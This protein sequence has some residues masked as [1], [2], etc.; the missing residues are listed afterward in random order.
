M[1]S[2]GVSQRLQKIA[3]SRRS[4][5]GRFRLPNVV[6]P[7]SLAEYVYAAPQGWT[8]TPYPDGIVLR[9]S[10]SNNGEPCLITM[11]PMRPAGVDLPRDADIAFQTIYSSYELRGRS[12]DG[13][14][15]PQTM[16]RG[17]SGQG[18]DYVMLKKAIGK[19]SNPPGQWGNAARLRHGREA[20]WQSRRYIGTVEATAGQYVLRRTDA[21]FVAPLLL[22]LA[23]QELARQGSN[24]CDGREVGWC[25]DQCDR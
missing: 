12:S 4:G 19:P 14:P 13:M 18:W 1:N 21:E 22:Q 17:T 20:G 11:W 9:P 15:V 3:L 6:G 16:I 25:L 23:V 24:V 8:T 5:R 2:V 7:N 10:A